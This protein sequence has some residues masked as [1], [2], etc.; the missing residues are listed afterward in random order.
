VRPTV[1]EQLAGAT[2]LLLLA[3]TT[4]S[5]DDVPEL[6]RNARRLVERVSDSWARALP[7]LEADNARTA[8]LLGEPVGEPA[9]D[10][11]AAAARNEE[12]RAALVERIRR[13]PRGADRDAIGAHLRER[14]ATDP[15]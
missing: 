12:L 9:G 1:D 11:S 2:R 5:T 6:V 7:F 10:L 3:E 4:K 14:V 15:T 13:L 8:A